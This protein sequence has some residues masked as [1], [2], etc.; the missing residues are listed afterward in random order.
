MRRLL[1]LMGLLASVVHAEEP[2]LVIDTGGHQSLIR[3]VIFTRDGKHLV[4]AGSD[5]VVRVWDVATGEPV[6]IIR[7][8]IGD[9]PAGKIY[10]AALSPDN[11]YLAVGGWLVGNPESRRAIRLHDF[12]T[13]NVVSLLKGHTRVIHDLAFSRDGRYLASG[14][15]DKTVRIWDVEQ[16]KE[17]HT[18]SGHQ[19]NVYAVGFSPDG[20]R[21]VSGSNDDTLRLWDVGEGALIREMLGHQDKVRAA[22]FSPEGRY[23]AS[24]SYDKTVRLWNA[25]T[26]QFMKVFDEAG[27]EV[28]SLA[29]SPDGQ[30]LLGSGVS[31]RKYDCVVFSVRSGEVITRFSK[32]DNVVI[33]TA[34][35]PDGSTAATAGGNDKPIYL[36]DIE[37]GNVIRS[38][39]GDG[40][41]ILATAFA[42]DAG[43]IAFGNAFSFR[44]L[45][46]RGPL[47][48]ILTLQQ[49]G[50]YQVTLGGEVQ[51]ES[52]FLRARET[53]GEF[54]LKTRSG[55]TVA[56]TYLQIL[57]GDTLSHEIERDETSGF[58]HNSFS[59]SPDGR[60]VASGGASG[61]LTLYSAETGENAADLTGHTSEVWSLAFSPDGRMLVS[62]SGDQTVRLWDVPSGRN[63]LT[64]F[65]GADDEWVAWTP[66]GYYTS[67]LNGD[68]YIGWHVNNGVDQ[69]ATYYGAAR[70]QK[71]LYRPDVVAEYLATRDIQSETSFQALLLALKR[72]NEKR[73][74]PGPVEPVFTP[75]DIVASAPPTVFFASPLRPET[76][77][78]EKTMTV[79]G[80]ARSTSL[81][82]TDVRV[83]LNNLQRYRL[84]PGSQGS[85]THRFEFEVELQ[86]GTNYL[87]AMAAHQ[88]AV[89]DF[90]TRTINFTGR[91]EGSKSN[92][93]LLAIGISEYK[94]PRFKLD[95]AHRDATKVEE[96]FLGQEGRL[97][98]QIQTKRLI[99][100]QATREEIIRTLSWLS[101]EGT[102]K[103]LR[104]L[105]L[106]GH[107]GRDSQQN[108][109]FYS[110]E[111]DP[112]EFDLYDIPWT[113]LLKKLTSANNKAL[114][115]VDTCHAAAAGGGKGKGSGDFSEIIKE[116]QSKYSGIVSFASST[117]NEKSVE[118]PEYE[119]GAFTQALI[120]GLQGKADTQ[121]K[122]GVI[123]TDEL[124][125]WIRQRVKQLNGE[126]HAISGK[127]PGLRHFPFFTVR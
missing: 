51:D 13:G 89:S 127:S 28:D 40:Q 117:H 64:V 126:Q 71:Q 1:I 108:Y 83:L 115:F 62:G 98:S 56:H 33:A 75:S 95:Y 118:L 119:Q 124:A 46:N 25:K 106:S 61:V 26:G 67:S 63:L 101:R 73:T 37:T 24:G 84:P 27:M 18:L 107:G 77:V 35:S 86:P 93:Y 36:W 19:D 47:Q 88:K 72:A 121:P 53:H 31:G 15:A 80:E 79:I 32:H 20:Q 55:P 104:V 8:E 81:P 22:T 38:L 41:R 123:H 39:A 23:I 43:S 54:T 69:L 122:D 50:R 94:N 74:G 12:K 49:E 87:S 42:S 100:G 10:A 112:D 120:E 109:Y 44:S 97:F 76:K 34:I 7:G 59:F 105:F 113:N 68:K 58:R 5:K 96:A 21:L 99:N 9:G 111:H 2:R 78:T 52:K 29:F 14:S 11:R 4:S 45:N 85:K 103:N 70:F 48:R 92:L 66:Q 30:R 114:L 116:M 17:L 82:L 90:E 65:V 6:R 57:K 110:H 16:R 3:D 91:A 102:Q 60:Y 125:I